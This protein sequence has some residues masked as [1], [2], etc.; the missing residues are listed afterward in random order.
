MPG[1]YPTAVGEVRI[2]GQAASDGRVLNPQTACRTSER[3]RLQRPQK[4]AQIV[5]VDII[6]AGHWIIYSRAP[7]LCNFAQR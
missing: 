3:L 6:R 5:P 2:R 7:P 1:G 4:V